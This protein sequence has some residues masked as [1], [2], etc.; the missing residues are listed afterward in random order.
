MPALIQK[1]RRGDFPRGK[2]I[3]RVLAGS[4]RAVPLKL[5][6]SPSD[7][8]AV[9]TPLVRS[10]AGA[11]VWWQLKHSP[12][13]LP[14]QQ[15]N[16]LKNIHRAYTLKSA[17]RE[18]ELGEVLRFCERNQVEP[19]LIK[20]WAI[21]R[22]YADPR[23]RPT[24]DVDLH[25]PLERLEELSI[26]WSTNPPVDCAVDWDHTEISKFENPDFHALHERAISA[27]I[28]GFQVKMPCLEDHLR[29]LCVHAL[30]HGAWRPLWMCDIAAALES[31]TGS[32]DWNRCLGPDGKQ[33]K[34]IICTLALAGR[35]LH[36]DV[37]DTPAADELSKVPKWVFE[38]VLRHWE[39][40]ESPVL[41][42][43]RSEIRNSDGSFRSLLKIIKSRW[44]NPIQATIDFK[45]NFS[46]FRPWSFQLRHCSARVWKTLAD[47]T[48]S[49]STV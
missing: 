2:L 38:T 39:N 26:K 48:S 33:A 44:P 20:G 4:W 37:Q 34:W 46:S 41:P 29:I 16:C 35:L 36:A 7:L 13:P 31:R 43:F 9:I 28:A 45:G 21:A 15:W 19:I 17:I 30:K 6:V 14:Q 1:S 10:G 22:H 12:L 8:S 32:F 49:G 27:T 40:C 25:V 42:G 3:A 18:R 5:Q 11:L 47:A 23:L 24:G